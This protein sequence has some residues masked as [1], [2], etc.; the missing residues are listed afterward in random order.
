MGTTEGSSGLDV[1]CPFRGLDGP[2][3]P[4][5]HRFL[6]TRGLSLLTSSPTH[7]STLP[8]ETRLFRP[9]CKRWFSGTDPT[10]PCDVSEYGLKDDIYWPVKPTRDH[11]RG[12]PAPIPM[13]FNPPGTDHRREK[14]GRD[15]RFACRVGRRNFPYSLFCV[16][17]RVSYSYWGIRVRPLGVKVSHPTP[18]R[19]CQPLINYLKSGRKIV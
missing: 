13:F 8:A 1:K 12:P 17:C 16:I 6:S 11:P 2:G 4:R 9:L 5:T 14:E 19:C 10:P 18:K 7:D 15:V 3:V